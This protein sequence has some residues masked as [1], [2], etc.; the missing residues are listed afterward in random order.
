MPESTPDT[1]AVVV[2]IAR[3]RACLH[4]RHERTLAELTAELERERTSRA[5]AYADA[6]AAQDGLITIAVALG[7]PSPLAIGGAVDVLPLLDRIAKLSAERVDVLVDG[8][9]RQA[10]RRIARAT[11]AGLTITDEGIDISQIMRRIAELGRFEAPTVESDAKPETND[12]I[13]DIGDRLAEDL[14]ASGRKLIDDLRTIV[15]NFTPR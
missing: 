11:G 10:L 8:L 6:T 5:Q 9:A 15:A 12:P 1:A 4:A 7:L 2:D 13:Q 3:G 14:A